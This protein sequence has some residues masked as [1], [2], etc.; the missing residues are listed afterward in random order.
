MV[1]PMTTTAP[2]RVLA[3]PAFANGD[4]PYHALLYGP[5]GQLGVTVEEYSPAALARGDW[6]VFHIHWPEFLIGR[7]PLWRAAPG[8]AAFIARLL[9]ARVA[10]RRVVW[11]LHNLEPHDRRP[12]GRA[13]YR[14]LS[15]LTDGVI[16]LS[17]ISLAAARDRYPALRR[18]PSVIV[19][20][21]HFRGV[22][23]RT[24]TKA[25]ARRSL[26]L[27]VDDRVLL[28]F[29]SIRPYK[30]VDR[31]VE[32]FSRT[33]GDR[34]R[35]LIA[36]RP[37]DELRAALEEAAA[38]DPRVRLHLDFVAE[39]AVERWFLAADLVVLPYDEG[40]LNS[41]V[42]LLGLSFDRVVLAP[43]AGSLPDLQQA[44]GKE[45]VRTFDQLD[46]IELLDGIDAALE[47]E[48]Q[49]APLDDLD[50][51]ALAARTAELYRALTASNPSSSLVQGA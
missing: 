31:L 35:L 4:N 7:R 48:G 40:V 32:I 37:T 51:P 20:H 36:G 28:F 23:P 43:H 33:P 44:A 1:S 25:A 8:I 14:T 47:V 5:M 3:W 41:S 49:E 30:Q 21:G 18:R 42:A 19:P 45:W 15:R 12:G 17:E 50:W 24:L 6:D 10:G 22:Y 38:A 46:P 29:G 13:I 9:R 26:G 39:D 27:D 11:T 2:L 34:L 16:G